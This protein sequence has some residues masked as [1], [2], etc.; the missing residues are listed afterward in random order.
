VVIPAY[1]G[2]RTIRHVLEKLTRDPAG[3]LEVIVVDDFSQDGTCALVEAMAAADPRIVLVRHPYNRGTFLAR[4]SGIQKARAPHVGFADADDWIEGEALLRMTDVAVE[5]DADMVL[6]G[7]LRSLNSGPELRF[8][9]FPRRATHESDIWGRFVRLEYGAGTMYNKIYRRGL[10]EVP[11][12]AGVEKRLVVAEDVIFNIPCFARARRVVV[13]P[14]LLYHYLATDQGQAVKSDAV[15][16]HIILYEAFA[17]ALEIFQHEERPFLDGIAELYRNQLLMGYCRVRDSAEL[18]PYRDRLAAALQRI[19]RIR[20]EFV[21]DFFN[22]DA[23]E[24]NGIWA[25]L[26]HIRGSLKPLGGAVRR[27]LRI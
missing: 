11:E 21:A 10:L 8:T 23:P 27:K 18:L 15:L 2:E 26:K 25:A 22:R 5:T 14:D 12:F 9:D 24:G 16:A 20:P 13:M 3:A 17:E 1:N 19:V 4:I 7:V 6:F